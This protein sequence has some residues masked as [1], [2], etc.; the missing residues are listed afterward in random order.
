M[1]LELPFTLMLLAFAGTTLVLGVARI[2]GGLWCRRWPT[3]QGTVLE[4]CLVGSRDAYVSRPVVRFRYEVG[5]AVHEGANVWGGSRRPAVLP[6]WDARAEA[7]RF[8][9]GD[10]VRVWY[11]P[12]HPERAVLR[13]GPEWSVS[14]LM[15]AFGGYYTLLMLKGLWD[16]R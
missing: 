11:H 4:S 3:T 2:A 9:P 8:R 13:P 16:A 5:G 1:P 14:L 10:A 6:T 7:A 15:V 12:A